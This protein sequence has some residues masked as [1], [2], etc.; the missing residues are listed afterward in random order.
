MWKQMWQELQQELPDDLSLRTGERKASVR[1]FVGEEAFAYEA[2]LAQVRL[3]TSEEKSSPL[4]RC[5]LWLHP[6]EGARRSCGC[7]SRRLGFRDSGLHYEWDEWML[8]P[9]SLAAR[10]CGRA[11][12]EANAAHWPRGTI[13]YPCVHSGRADPLAH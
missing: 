4:R 5:C 13:C 7:D 11:I 3:K 6:S 1:A 9:R 2:G 10:G 8:K 12:L